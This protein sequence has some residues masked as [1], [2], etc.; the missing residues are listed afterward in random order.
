[1]IDGRGA[2]QATSIYDGHDG[3]L[4]RLRTFPYPNS[5]GTLYQAFTHHLGFRPHADEWKVMGLAAYGEPTIPMDE[6]IRVS[7]DDYWVN[8]NALPRR[9][10]DD[11]LL[12]ARFGPRREPE[13][14]LLDD[15]R[16][17]AASVQKAVEDAILMLA[18][19]AV[20][21]TGRRNLCLA[22]GVAMNSKAN[23]AIAASGLVDRLFIQPAASDDGT[24]LGAAIACQRRLRP[25]CRCGRMEHAYLGPAFST[26]QV[27]QA[28]DSAGLDYDQVPDIEAV[29]AR[30]LAAGH[31]VGWFQG[32]M[33]FGPRALGS[34]SILGDPRDAA[35]RDR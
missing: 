15:H 26:D 25:P 6:F 20:Q 30:L 1:M 14:P 19:N 22:G 28:L 34:R 5:L 35:T 32:R 16:N 23:G 9:G 17:L 21:L 7:D 11:P 27:R 33:E 18:R 4:R 31:V 29:A 12:R 10:R 3:A 13:A 24:A 8:K 2:T